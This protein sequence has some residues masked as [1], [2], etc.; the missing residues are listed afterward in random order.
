MPDDA[1]AL[2]VAQPCPAVSG[3]IQ[4]EP[5]ETGWN[6]L[7]PA[8]TDLAMA[9]PCPVGGSWIWLGSAGTGYVC[10]G[11]PRPPVP[12]PLLLLGPAMA[13]AHGVEEYVWYR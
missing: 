8:G 10:L 13:A 2:A 6:W 4:L 5:A 3:W 12:D 1:P 7:C 9:Q 11:Q